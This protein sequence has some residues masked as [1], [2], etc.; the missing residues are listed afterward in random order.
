MLVS[1]NIVFVWEIPES[2]NSYNTKIIYV[3]IIYE[4]HYLLVKNLE[5]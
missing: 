2:S 1:N 5:N 4:D 3:W